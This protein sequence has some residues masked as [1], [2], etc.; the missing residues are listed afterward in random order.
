VERP[1]GVVATVSAAPQ[2]EP[3]V[4]TDINDAIMQLPRNSTFGATRRGFPRLV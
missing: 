2:R 4:R 1:L 3:S